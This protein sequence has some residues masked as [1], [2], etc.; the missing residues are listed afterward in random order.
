MDGQD[1]TGCPH[2]GY[3]LENTLEYIRNR[4]QV[5]D[6]FTSTPLDLFPFPFRIL[7]CSSCFHH[8]RSN[9]APITATRSKRQ[10]HTVLAQS[11]RSSSLPS[12]LVCDAHMLQFVCRVGNIEA[13]NMD[14]RCTDA[15]DLGLRASGTD[16][17]VQ[18]PHV[19]A[20]CGNIDTALVH[21]LSSAPLGIY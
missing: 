12:F 8:L 18:V 20:S 16:V 9:T 11:M 14:L 21:P 2:A 6:T 15:M 10:P 4:V 7:P 13:T 3:Y 1:Q 17:L 19:K 5:H